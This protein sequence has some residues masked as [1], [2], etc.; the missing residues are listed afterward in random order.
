MEEEKSW[1]REN[2]LTISPIKGVES[3]LMGSQ[4]QQR[5]RR[6]DLEFGKSNIPKIEKN[7]NVVD[8]SD[9]IEPLIYEIEEVECRMTDIEER[10]RGTDDSVKRG[11]IRASILQSPREFPLPNLSFRVNESHLSMLS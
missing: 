4:E 8:D 10:E 2:S 3:F 7:L 11:S 5:L 1:K 9:D 6:I